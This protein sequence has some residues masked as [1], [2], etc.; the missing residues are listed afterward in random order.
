KATLDQ[1]GELDES[2]LL[3]GSLETVKRFT[4]QL[5]KHYRDGRRTLSA[6]YLEETVGRVLLEERRYARRK[7]FGGEVVRALFHL[8]G[9]GR[10]ITCYLP[11]AA[12]ERLPMLPE[13][14]AR[15]VAEVHVKQDQY[16]PSAHVLRVVTL[17]RVIDVG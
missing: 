14:G 12:A 1:I 17:G 9:D 10:A 15:I 11:E 4:D 3:R 16:D 8:R 13:I 7:L 2:P 6:E 5:R